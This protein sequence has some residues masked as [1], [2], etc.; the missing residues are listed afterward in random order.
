LRVSQKVS[1]SLLVVMSPLDSAGRAVSALSQTITRQSQGRS[2][3]YRL[4]LQNSFLSG[5]VIIKGKEV[6][7]A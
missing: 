2:Q 3:Y 6:I 4:C 1:R 7:D 5:P